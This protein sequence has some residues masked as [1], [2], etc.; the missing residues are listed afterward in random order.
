MKKMKKFCNK[1][2]AIMLSICYILFTPLTVLAV[3]PISSHRMTSGISN[4]YIYID[5]KLP[6]KATYWQ[7]LIKT[8]VDNW[9]YTGVGANKF[10]CQGYVSSG[11]SGSKIDFYARPSDYFG[12]NLNEMMGCT[13]FMSYSMNFVDPKNSDWYSAQID[14]N[15]PLL[16]RDSVSN[17]LAIALFIHEMGHAFGLD[18]EYTNMDSI[19]F[20]AVDASHTRRVQRVDNDALNTM[21]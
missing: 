12:N 17:D 20:W 14:L 11:T 4:I 8:A 21:Y 13:S 1:T 15:D 2:T 5:D 7:N 18:D 3:Q 19:M 10:Y 6:L 16:R 9:M